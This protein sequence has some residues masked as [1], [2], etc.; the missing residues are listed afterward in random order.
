VTTSHSDG[1][2]ITG[3]VVVAP[4][5]FHGYFIEEQ[6]LNYGVQWTGDP[7]SRVNVTGVLGL[8]LETGSNLWLTVMN[9]TELLDAGKS[10]VSNIFSN[11]TA[12][13]DG[14]A[15]YVTLLLQRKRDFDAGHRPGALTI[16]QVWEGYDAIL[17]ADEI[18]VYP[19]SEPPSRWT[20]PLTDFLVNDASISYPFQNLAS[21]PASTP[22]TISSPDAPLAALIDSYSSL[23]HLPVVLVD[24]TYS[25]IH[26]AVRYT[27]SVSSP[28]P[29][30]KWV[31]PCHSD[32]PS[33]SFVIGS[34]KII[35]H[36][37]DVSL[38]RVFMDSKGQFRSLCIGG[39]VGAEKRVDGVAGRLGVS[40]LR[41]VYMM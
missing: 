21:A 3:P 11:T 39:L 32:P 41:N 38:L 29:L 1:L 5:Q 16:G 40:F 37:L 20:V 15:T 34:Q 2:N 36:P 26:G 18:P 12:I 8:G 9:M 23:T 19:T 33:V 17:D 24:A 30:V 10:L 35:I 7:Y 25:S 22:F 13:S 31:L 28:T 27:S 4:I 14:N 6:A